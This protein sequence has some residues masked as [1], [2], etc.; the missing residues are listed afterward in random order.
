[1]KLFRLALGALCMVFGLGR[2][3]AQLPDGLY[4]R[5]TTSMGVIT[6]KLYYDKTPRTVAH[7]VALAE[8]TQPFIDFVNVTVTNRHFYDGLTFHRV[9]KGFV[10]QTGSPNGQGTD[11]PGYTIAN[12]IQAG[13]THSKAGILGAARTQQQNTYGAQFYF[14]L[15]N[16]PSLDGQYT[17]WGETVEGLDVVLAIGNVATDVNDKPTTPVVLQ[18]VEILRIGAAAQ[19]FDPAK[20]TPALPLARNK[21]MEILATT[22]SLHFTW[23]TNANAT[24]RILYNS[25]LTNWPVAGSDTGLFRDNQID[26]TVLF[27]NNPAYFFRLFEV[28]F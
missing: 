7:F 20:V 11:G 27:T 3:A 2:V 6:A 15:T 26:G 12:E 19:A 10:I 8:G 16:T 22:N 24:Y 23:Q 14:T 1:M 18:K 5:F 9:I 4:A 28:Q 25:G 21:E 17:V 13:L